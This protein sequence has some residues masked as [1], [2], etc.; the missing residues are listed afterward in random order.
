MEQNV[1]TADV[2][3]S[4]NNEAFTRKEFE[5]VIKKLKHEKAE[6]GDSIYN[7]MIKNAP[8]VIL[9]LLFHFI[10]TCLEKSLIPIYFMYLAE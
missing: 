8:K 9:D 4:E 7:G 3:M 10:N 2:G 5:D 6:G 1:T